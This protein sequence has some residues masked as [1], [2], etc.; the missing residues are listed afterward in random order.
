L[1][2]ADRGIHSPVALVLAAGSSSRVRDAV[3]GIPKPLIQIGGERILVRNLRWLASGGVHEIW[4]NLHYRPELIRQAIGDGHALGVTV[5]YSHET[6]L[7]GTA[8][9]AKNLEAELRKEP[10]WVV[11]G[12]NLVDVDLIGMARAHAE[13]GA[14]AT[15]ALF[16][17][18]RVANTGIAGGRAS[19][20]NGLISAFHEGGAGGS[21]VNAGIYLLEHAVL[22]HIPE[23][24]FV[25]FGRDIFPAL[26]KSGERIQ[27]Y[28][29]GRYCLAVDTPEALARARQL[30][31]VLQ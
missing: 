1:T 29:V 24:R 16:D 11:Y 19:V 2:G 10:F 7:L 18:H 12:D 22:D 31:A 20:V 9:A 25:D 15:I 30:V 4:I 26:L 5:S 27:A 28:P 8:G 23:G 17:P 3:L 21:W 14:I 13:S 6:R